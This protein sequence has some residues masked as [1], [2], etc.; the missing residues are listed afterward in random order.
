MELIPNEI[1]AIIHA[2]RSE[3]ERVEDEI[4][5]ALSIY[6]DIEHRISDMLNLIKNMDLSD[7][8]GRN[9]EVMLSDITAECR[10]LMSV[11]IE[12]QTITPVQQL[13]LNNLSEQIEYNHIFQILFHPLCSFNLF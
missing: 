13:M 10:K 8:Y 4:H 12:E 11:I 2:Y 3:F 5:H 6:Y 9:I 7:H 1:E